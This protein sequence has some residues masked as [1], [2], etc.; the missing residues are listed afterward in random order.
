M[1]F[2]VDY[3]ITH[4]NNKTFDVNKTQLASLT[5]NIL[6]SSLNMSKVDQ[7][8]AGQLAQALSGAED[9]V[10]NNSLLNIL[11]DF[12]TEDDSSFDGLSLSPKQKVALKEAISE[13]MKS[14]N[15]SEV[16]NLL[17]LLYKNP[18]MVIQQL[19]GFI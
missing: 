15:Y 9:K 7:N 17:G 16:K 13:A 19:M 10:G 1:E 8:K 5:Q 12:L 11:F 14:G 6:T 2:T 3:N 18:D 4:S